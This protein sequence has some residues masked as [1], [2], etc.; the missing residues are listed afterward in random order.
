[1]LPYT[2]FGANL[3]NLL[4]NLAIFLIPIVSC[5]ESVWN[6]CFVKSLITS[7]A[8]YDPC[9]LTQS[10]TNSAIGAAKLS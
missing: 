1:M 2:A 6:I 7:P 4:K 8:I 5:D 10:A 9:L 3:D